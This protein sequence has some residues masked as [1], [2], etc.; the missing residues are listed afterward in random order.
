VLLIHKEIKVD[1]IEK[2]EDSIAIIGNFLSFCIFLI[3]LMN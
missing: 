3:S 2:I 1:E